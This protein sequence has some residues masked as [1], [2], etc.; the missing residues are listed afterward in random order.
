MTPGAEPLLEGRRK[1]SHTYGLRSRIEADLWQIGMTPPPQQRQL[2]EQ[3]GGA[4][5]LLHLRIGRRHPQLLGQ[6]LALWTLELEL[7]AD[8]T[9]ED[10]REDGHERRRQRRR[11]AAV[12]E[13]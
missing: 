9:E 2:L 4:Q 6:P 1:A 12:P 5:A 3:A 11:A 8:Q 7:G 10:P 13:A